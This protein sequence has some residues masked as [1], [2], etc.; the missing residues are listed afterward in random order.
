MPSIGQSG[1]YIVIFFKLIFCFLHELQV[2]CMQI[3]RGLR[4]TRAKILQ[5]LSLRE[6]T[7]QTGSCI[8]VFF[9]LA[10]RECLFVT[11]F[12]F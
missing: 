11:P 3:L 7:N 9:A 8:K 2:Q 1:K 6:A 12:S 5:K 4:C 10:N